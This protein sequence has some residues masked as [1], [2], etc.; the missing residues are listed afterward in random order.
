M[1]EAGTDDLLCFWSTLSQ[2][3]EG[4]F[5]VQKS[6]LNKSKLA[7]VPRQL[8]CTP[9]TREMP[10]A[11]LLPFVVQSRQ[12]LCTCFWSV[13]LA[14]TRAAGHAEPVLSLQEAVGVCPPWL[15]PPAGSALLL[16]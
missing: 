14:D 6:L 8:P 11:A 7:Q 13:G 4:A 12:L 3:Y 16:S 2:N 9:R 15:L 1:L 5:L 10:R